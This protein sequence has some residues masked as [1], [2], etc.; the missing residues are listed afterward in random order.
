MSAKTPQENIAEVRNSMNLTQA[1][2][3]H[4]IG[5]SRQA[6]INLEHGKTSVINKQITKMAKSCGIT[7]E[8]ILFGYSMNELSSSMLRENESFKDQMNAIVT[9]KDEMIERLRD[10]LDDL[11]QLVFSERQ[12]GRTQSQLI[13]E[14]KIRIAHL[15]Q[16][17]LSLRKE[18]RSFKGR[19]E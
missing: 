16:E 10:K 18:L 13:E 5:I 7:E 15:A 2:M 19:R 12:N 17:N 11:T 14:Q 8:K 9:E 6:Y 1:E 3:A 4:K